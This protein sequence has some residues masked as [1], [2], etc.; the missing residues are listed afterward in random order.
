MTPNAAIIR[1][2]V[3][4]TSCTRLRLMRSICG[5]D[6]NGVALPGLRRSYIAT[7]GGHRPLGWSPWLFTA[8]LARAIACQA[9]NKIGICLNGQIARPLRTSGWALVERGCTWVSRTSIGARRDFPDTS[10][11]ARREAIAGRRLFSTLPATFPQSLPIFEH[12]DPR[13]Q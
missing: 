3:F 5:I 12:L 2:P 6:R 8:A 10:L 4:S 9:R 1:V 7:R 11:E 13:I